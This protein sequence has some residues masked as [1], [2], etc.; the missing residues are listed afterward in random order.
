M[1]AL[2]LDKIRKML[3]EMGFAEVPEGV[4]P[5]SSKNVHGERTYYFNDKYCRPQYFT[6]IGFFIEYAESFEDAKKNWYDDG[7]GFPL[8]LGENTILNE[9]RKEL[10]SSIEEINK[11][12]LHQSA[13]AVAV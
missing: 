10:L 6:S 4:L 1:E 12:K 5:G 8:E 9:L 2:I 11:H 7:E 3:I 13:Y